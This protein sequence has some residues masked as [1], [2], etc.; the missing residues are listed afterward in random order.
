MKWKI[1]HQLLRL[2]SFA[3]TL[4]VELCIAFLI[5]LDPPSAERYLDEVLEIILV[6]SARITNSDE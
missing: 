3:E 5:V 4:C 2:I 1:P 6:F